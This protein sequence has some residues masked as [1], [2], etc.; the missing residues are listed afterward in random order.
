MPSGPP[1]RVTHV[2]FD[3]DGT[4]VDF[5]ASLRAGLEAASERIA[6]I[7]GAFIA[8]NGL[9]ALRERVM[10]EPEWRGRGLRAIREE[11]FRRVLLA[12][13][14]ER[15]DAVAELSRVYYRA[16]DEALRP[17]DD[18]EE[19]MRELHE[20]GFC[21]V[22]ASNGNAVL[23]ALAFFRY[24]AHLHGAE[25][26]GV[27]KPDPRFFAGALECAGGT[28]ELAVSVGDRIEN[29]YEPARAI[30]MHAVLLDRDGLVSDGAV[31]KIRSLRELPAMLERA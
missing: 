27:E 12:A 15:S 23:D 16:R 11:T 6:Q 26:A 14:N 28:P 2:V 4:L 29:D 10:V 9:Q 5:E 19:T 21:L 24:L 7:A 8:P 18:V 31:V 3:V 20:R 1:F 25:H 13:G 22:A 17:Y 30:G